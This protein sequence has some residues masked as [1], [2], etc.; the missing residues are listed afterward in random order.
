MEGLRHLYY[1][2]SFTRLA[3]QTNVPIDESRKT[4]PKKRLEALRLKIMKRL[5]ENDSSFKGFLDCTLWG[6][7]F[8]FD[9]S[10]SK[11][12][13]HASHQ[14]IHQQFAMV[15]RMVESQNPEVPFPSFACGDMIE[16]FIRKYE[17]E[18]GKSFFDCYIRAVRNNQRMD[19]AYAESSLIIYEDE[20]VMLFVPKA[21]TSQWEIQ[22]MPLSPVGN[23]LEADTQVRDSLDKA[24]LISMKV[25]WNL[26][27]RMVTTIEY[28]KRMAVKDL[29]QRLLYAFLPKI[30]YSMGA[31]SEAQLRWIN[32]H[33][34]EDFAS[35]CRAQL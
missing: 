17:K 30:P 24:I 22:L 21:Q 20:N 13:L 29:D 9:F 31:F 10:T 3:R 19:D 25:L 26:G 11:Y 2:R 32:G 34:P 33:F 8:G 6:W 7:N 1:Q 15:P 12:R 16:E 4:I 5:K 23:I 35:A 27:A 14:Q 28:A 18:T